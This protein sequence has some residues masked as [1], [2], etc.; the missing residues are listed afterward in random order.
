MVK[1]PRRRQAAR[2]VVF[3]PAG[4]VLRIS[5]HD[6][7]RRS[8]GHWWEVPGGGIDPGEDTHHAVRRELWEEAGIADAEIGPVVFTQ[9]VEFTFGGWHFDQDEWIH[10]ARCS[11]ESTGPKGL[12]ALEAMAFGEQRWWEAEDLIASGERTIPYPLAEHLIAL[13]DWELPPEPI[14]ITPTP[15][16]VTAWRG[17][18]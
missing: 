6:A 12:E 18:P 8:D 4:R 3:D 15:D 11:G 16:E 7:A 9:A 14:D 2:V 5:A 10:V 17:Q 1:W 13:R